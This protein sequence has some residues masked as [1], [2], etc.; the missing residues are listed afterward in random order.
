[1][2]LPWGPALVILAISNAGPALAHTPMV[3]LGGFSGGLL[4]PVLVPA[5]GLALL[6]LGLL[7]GQQA[8]RDRFALLLVFAAALLAGIGAIV[9]A[10]AVTGAATVILAIAGVLGILV[11][12]GLPA[13]RV[14]SAGLA[15][16]LGAA[17]ALDSVPEAISMRASLIELAGTAAGA[18][19]IVTIVAALA[20]AGKRPWQRIGARILASWTAASAIFVLALQFAR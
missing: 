1:M 6:G 5:H 13:L 3:G 20:A 4:H 11:A 2:K 12:V 9:A 18:G 16:I 15:A 10:V 7:V 19:L 8:L 14:V 17:L